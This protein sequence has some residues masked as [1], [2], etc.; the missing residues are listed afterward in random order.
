MPDFVKWA[1]SY[2]CKAVRVTEASE[3]QSA[4]DM[5][6]AEKHAPTLIEFMISSDELVLPMVKNGGAMNDMIL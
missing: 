1:E 6:K 3:I 4:L 5:A 2:G